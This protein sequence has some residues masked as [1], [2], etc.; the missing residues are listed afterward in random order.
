[1]LIHLLKIVCS[2][3]TLSLLFPRWQDSIGYIQTVYN[4]GNGRKAS[5]NSKGSLMAGVGYAGA[6]INGPAASALAFLGMPF[7]GRY[8]GRNLT[9]K[10]KVSEVC[11]FSHLNRTLDIRAE[12]KFVNPDEAKRLVSEDGYTILDIRDK[13]QYERAHIKSCYHVPL[14]IENNDSDL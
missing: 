8:S 9:K 3:R 4:E 1:M 5:N 2:R 12:V 7:Q 6:L 14:F 10:R 13:T 11:S